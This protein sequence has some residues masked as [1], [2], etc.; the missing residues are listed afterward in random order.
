[1]PDGWSAITANALKQGE[2][3]L[4]AKEKRSGRFALRAAPARDPKSGTEYAFIVRSDDFAVN[5]ATD[6]IY[7]IWL[8]ASGENAPVDIALLDGTY[9]GQGTYCERILVGREWKRYELKC[10][11]HNEFTT[12][13]VGF[14]VYTGTVWAD[15]A[16]VAEVSSASARAP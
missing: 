3:V 9:K 5:A 2:M 7:S 8:K 6:V 12:A 13:C 1:M 15:D 4:D 11:L 16:N 10:R 14:K